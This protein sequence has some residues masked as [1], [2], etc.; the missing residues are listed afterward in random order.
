MRAATMAAAQQQ[1][2]S[3]YRM[4]QLSAEIA[5]TQA[6]ISAAQTI[7]AATAMPGTATVQAIYS[8]QQAGATATAWW[9]TQTPLAATA[10]AIAINSRIERLRE[11]KERSLANLIP[12]A[13][14]FGILCAGLLIGYSIKIWIEWT[15][16]R[17]R[18]QMS[19][20][21]S[22]AGTLVLIYM[23]DLGQYIW[24]PVIGAPAIRQLGPVESDFEP[25][26]ISHG[27]VTATGPTRA[28]TPTERLLKE[29]IE[30]AGEESMVFP[31]W[32]ALLKAGYSWSSEQWQAA[33]A[34]LRR[35]G[36]IY[37]NGKGTFV[38]GDYDTLADVRYAVETHQLNISPTPAAGD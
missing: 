31:S 38:G 4:T 24:Q 23:E 6:A 7:S 12:I 28:E 26:E 25:V 5:G 37:P 2:E 22:R 18:R 33:I 34:P 35:A 32:R 15:I 20:R 13:L 30:L 27:G 19:V 10:E 29:A 16:D 36:A 21:E 17:Q 14:F 1:E 11:D 9:V 3:I 8:T